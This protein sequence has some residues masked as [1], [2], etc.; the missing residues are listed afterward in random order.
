M[1][2]QEKKASIVSPLDICN[3]GGRAIFVP[4]VADPDAHVDNRRKVEA[5]RRRKAD[6]I[7]LTDTLS[8]STDDLESNTIVAAWL[9]VVAVDTLLDQEDEGQFDCTFLPSR[10]NTENLVLG[11]DSF[12]RVTVM[13]ERY[14]AI[15]DVGERPSG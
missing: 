14:S 12:G 1:N 6:H 3:P 8:V 5:A 10:F 7:Q 11:T 15:V 9:D 13:F 4:I 2:E